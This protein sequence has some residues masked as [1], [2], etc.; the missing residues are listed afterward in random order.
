MIAVGNKRRA[1]SISLGDGGDSDLLMRMRR[2]GNFIENAP[3]FL[4]LLSLFEMLGGAPAIVTAFAGIFIITRLSHAY[5]LSGEGK[6][7][8]FRVT[9]ALGTA[10][11]LLGTAG[12]I[13]WQVNT[14]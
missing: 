14:L 5:A 1:A 12:F 6:P 2:H 8:V 3:M 7:V 9:G 13:L 10:V 4:I 11:S